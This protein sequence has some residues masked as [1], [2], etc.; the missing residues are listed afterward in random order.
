MRGVP[1]ARPEAPSLAAQLAGAGWYEREI[2]EL[3]GVRFRGLPEAPPLLLNETWDAPPPLAE[4]KER[5]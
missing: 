4:R 3:L 5:P 2:Q 1:R